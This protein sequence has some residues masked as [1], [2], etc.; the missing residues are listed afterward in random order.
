LVLPDH[1]TPIELMT[2]SREPV[3]FAISG[4]GI[5]PD[6]IKAFNEKAI[7]RSSLRIKHGHKLLEFLLKGRR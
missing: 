3:P 1:P 2:H 6:K 7:S 4:T 5:K